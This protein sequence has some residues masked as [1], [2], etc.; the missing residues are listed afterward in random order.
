MSK[1]YIYGYAGNMG[2]RYRAILGALGHTWMGEDVGD[3]SVGTVEESDAIIVATPTDTHV[4][5]LRALKD[6]GKPV[7]CE[8][9]ITMDV[10]ELRALM[11]ELVV[12]GTKLQMVSQYDYLIDPKSKGP[13]FYDYFKSGRDGLAWD[14]IQIISHAK[15]EVVLKNE[16]P[17]WQCQINGK[18]L[19]ISKMDSAYAAMVRDWLEAPRNDVSRILDSHQKVVEWLAKS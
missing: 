7:L 5:V 3:R 15:G 1:V 16:S 14:C 12:A 13:T 6:C 19:D 11:A 9:P 18:L 2:Q 10:T 8:K 17:I 4:E